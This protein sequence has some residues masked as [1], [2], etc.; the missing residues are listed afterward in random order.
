[1]TWIVGQSG[2]SR[3]RT[4]FILLALLPAGCAS[5]G[6]AT[7]SRD[8]VDY[9][10][11][12]ADSWKEQTLLNI[13]RMRYGD[14]PSFVDVSSII[15]A[16]ALQGQ[17]SAAGQISSDLTGTI[18]SNL[19][20]LGG[21]VTYL[22]RPTITYTP[23]AG[24]KF[25]ASLLRPIPPSAIF[26]LIQAGYPA[27]YILQMTTRAINGVYNRSSIG[28]QVREADP[29]FYPLLNALRRLQLSGAVS[30][31]LEKHGKEETGILI[32][33]PARTPEISG[34]LKLVRDTLKVRPGPN[35]ELTLIFGALPQNAQEIALLSR[36]MLGIL[37]EVA[38]GI[39]VPRADVAA[40]RTTPSASVMTAP[41]PHDRPLVHVSSGPAPPEGAFAAV[42]YRGSWYWIDDRD[43]AS[44]RIFTFLMMFFSL[45]E[46]GVT[47]Q[48]PV[49]T[50]PAT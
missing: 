32:L 43:F 46:T 8:R 3:A 6:P 41:D 45:A 18:P 2:A 42:R 47:P 35:G 10:G 19:V 38:N 16:Y 20:T 25:A 29:S 40:G 44:K 27:D 31:R 48:T 21:G 28:G 36:S 14:A 23:L 26:E 13:V 17:L 39:D 37:L 49:L 7:V 34:D 9:I 12:V 22:D 30:L 11:A 15:S 5:I 50:V 4:A 33:S 1:M 24:E